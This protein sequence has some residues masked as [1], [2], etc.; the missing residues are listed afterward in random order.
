[1]KNQI[2]TRSKENSAAVIRQQ[3]KKYSLTDLNSELKNFNETQLRVI[4]ARINS[5]ALCDL[6]LEHFEISLT[7]IL[8]N[9]SVICGCQLPTHDAHINALEKEFGIFLKD[10]GYIGLTTEEILTAF[11]FNANFKLE[12]KVESY[13]AVFNINFAAQVLKQYLRIRGTVD[14]RAEK[15]FYEK[16]V[17]IE[18][19][20]E[21]DA[22]RK[23]IIQQFE[24]FLKDENAALDLSN[25]F[26]QL[27]MD[28]AFSNK[29][30]ND[31]LSYYFGTDAESRLLASF[32][33]LEKRFDRE[34][35]VVKFLFENMKKSGRFEIYSKDLNLVHPGFEL[36]DNFLIKSGVSEKLDF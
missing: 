20:K 4:D 13:G 15:I 7:G 22:R 12:E 27:R 36:P 1:M 24:L 30:I 33:H 16:D 25:C 23:K 9:I 8:F 21:E 14:E 2:Q 17:K 3:G 35:A 11:R 10:N 32:E 34:K 6:S 18:L 5:P 29:K 19:G 28:G 26:M 31:E